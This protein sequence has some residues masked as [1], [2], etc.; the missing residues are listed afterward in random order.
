MDYSQTS[1]LN[2]PIPNSTYSTERVNVNYYASQF[3][4][5][6]SSNQLI[7]NGVQNGYREQQNISNPFFASWEQAG[8]GQAPPPLL[9]AYGVP[10]S[11]SRAYCVANRSEVDHAYNLSTSHLAEHSASSNC[12]C[13][14]KYTIFCYSGS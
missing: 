4:S 9:D 10:V 1:K 11:S 8:V 12:Y 6:T 13:Q 3:P 7:P 2:H 5:V 14:G